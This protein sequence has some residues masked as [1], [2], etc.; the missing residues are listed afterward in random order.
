MDAGVRL[1]AEH[2]IDNVSLREITRAAG[3]RNSVALQHHFGD[4]DGLLRAIVERYRTG[5]EVRRH[6]R[7]DACGDR[8]GLRPLAEALVVPLAACLHEDGGPAFLQIFAD[9]VN[10]PR[11]L[12]E[13]LQP[14]G[15]DI[16][17]SMERWR[18]MLDPL[19]PRG[20]AHV[21]RRFSA[22]LYASVEMARCAR[23]GPQADTDTDVVTAAT[24]DVV[25]AILSAPVSAETARAVRARDARRARTRSSA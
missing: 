17:D 8:P 20:A 10:R 24:V 3:A 19:L 25:A 11:P 21:H 1:F 13:P 14:T 2:G 16:D 12:L 5:I 6:E 7:L 22:T 4:R 15:G 23:S 9:L 18:R